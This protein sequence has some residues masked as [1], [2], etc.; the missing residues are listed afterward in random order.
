MLITVER[1]DEAKRVLVEG[2]KFELPR[3]IEAFPSANP[4]IA[5]RDKKNTKK[6]WRYQKSVKGLLRR[7]KVK[8]EK[9][10]VHQQ[11]QSRRR[12]SSI[13]SSRTIKLVD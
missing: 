10:E 2:E 7:K 8:I 11:K 5:V 13:A 3:E 6:V 12:I 9:Q 1:F 4:D